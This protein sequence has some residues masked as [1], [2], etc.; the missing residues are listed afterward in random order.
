MTASPKA[1]KRFAQTQLIRLELQLPVF[2][3]KPS[4]DPVKQNAVFSPKDWQIDS[5]L[6]EL[7]G[8]RSTT[9]NNLPLKR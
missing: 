2:T 9:L 7:A 3:W 1:L 5:P 8:V 4:D 6:S